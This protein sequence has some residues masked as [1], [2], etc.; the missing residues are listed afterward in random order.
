MPMHA[1]AV[2][3]LPGAGLADQPDHLVGPHAQGGRSHDATPVVVDAV[4]TSRSVTARAP[5]GLVSRLPRQSPPHTDPP[6]SAHVRLLAPRA[7]RRPSAT[8]AHDSTV[9]ISTMPGDHSRYGWSSRPRRV[10]QHRPPAGR[11]RLHAEAEEAERRLGQDRVPNTRLMSTSNGGKRWAGCGPNSTRGV[12]QPTQ[13]DAM[14]NGS[15]F[16]LR[17]EFRTRRKKRA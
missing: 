1:I 17:V 13:T 3:V 12:A 5:P 7:S 15:A 4:T 6:F 10:G 14:T 2:T 9:R 8:Y 11:R 16:R